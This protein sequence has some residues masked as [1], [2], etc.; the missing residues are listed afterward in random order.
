MMLFRLSYRLVFYRKRNRKQNEIIWFSFSVLHVA[1]CVVSLSVISRLGRIRTSTSD[2]RIVELY[3][4][5][6]K[7]KLR[8]QEES[9]FRR[10]VNSQPLCL[11]R[12][13]ELYSRNV[14]MLVPMYRSAFAAAKS[15]IPVML[16]R[17]DLN[18]QPARYKRAALT[19]ELQAIFIFNWSG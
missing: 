12:G 10:K 5:S 1:L 6:Y 17:Q 18:L 11:R 8:E 19:V 9:N 7:P 15:Y 2:G 13:E 3:P 16:T 14:E 4:L